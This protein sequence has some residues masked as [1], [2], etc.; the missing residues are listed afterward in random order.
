MN[1]AGTAPKAVAKLDS[2]DSNITLENN[3]LFGVSV[4]GIGDLNE[5]GIN[6]LAVGA[7]LDNAQGSRNL[8][9]LISKQRRFN[10]RFF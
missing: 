1:K 10:K 8:T 7:L 5:D 6:D 3:D 4:A 9:Y 2:S